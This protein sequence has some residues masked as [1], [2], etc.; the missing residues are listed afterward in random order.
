MNR[1]IRPVGKLSRDA[2]TAVFALTEN[3]CV[4]ASYASLLEYFK[5]L[6][7]ER[8]KWVADLRPSQ[9]RTGGQCSLH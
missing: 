2:E 7:S 5:A 6:P 8:M 4:D 9:I 1:R 3:Q